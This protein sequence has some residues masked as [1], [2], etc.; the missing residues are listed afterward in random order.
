MV[1]TYGKITEEITVKKML[2]IILVGKI[3]VEKQ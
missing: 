3:S 1:K 2:K